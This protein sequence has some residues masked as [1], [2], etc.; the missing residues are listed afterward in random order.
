MTIIYAYLAII[1]TMCGFWLYYKRTNNPGI[2]DVAWSLCH[3]VG[4]S[5]YLLS[6]NMASRKII[7]WL[8]LSIWAVRLAGYLYWTRIRIGEVDKRYTK[9]SEGWKMAP[10]FGFFLNFQF[11]GFLVMFIII[12]IYLSSHVSSSQLSAFDWIG[13]TLI[14]AGI[15]GET[16]S[17]QQLRKFVKK[18]KGQVCNV[19]LWHYSRHPNYFFEWLVWVGFAV[20]ALS[21]SYGWLAIIS[22]LT[23]YL[24]MTKL[25]GPITE[26]GSVASK[27][28]AYEQYQQT[29]SMFFPLPLNGQKNGQS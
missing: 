21:A 9:L 19:G 11:Q 12:S 25:T 10:S 24:I 26:K 2:V 3:W 15:V 27:G 22:P 5:I 8:L 28:Q 4:G 1:F 14:V 7:L 17:D 6:G 20:S 13:V 18:N 29:T 23:L 16:I